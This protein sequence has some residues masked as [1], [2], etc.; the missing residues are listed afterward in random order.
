MDP[1]PDL[2]SGLLHAETPTQQVQPIH[3]ERGEFA[4]AAPGVRSGDDKRPAA[5]VD[6][7][8]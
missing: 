8:G 5:R 4:K 6:G 3:P 2:T 7:L 1:A